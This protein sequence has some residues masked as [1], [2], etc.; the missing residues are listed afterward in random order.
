MTGTCTSIRSL[1]HLPLVAVV[2][3]LACMPAAA[4]QALT[5]YSA[6]Y[7]VKLS[8]LSGSLTTNL[9]RTGD[10]YEAVH[11]IVPT[12]LARIIKN[13]SIRE[14]SRFATIGDGVR[15]SWYQSADSLSKD[16]P[17]AEVEFDWSSNEMSGTVNGE[18]VDVALDGLVHD[19]VAIQYELMLDLLNGGPGDRYLLFDIDEFKTLIVTKVGEKRIKTPA[20][21]Y[22]AI[23]I[24]HQS[25]NSSRVTTLWCAAALGYLPVLI[26][27]HRK[28]KLQMRATLRDYE[29][30]AD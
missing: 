13:G 2:A 18:S 25:E 9:R 10:G 7:K 21:T 19:R 30:A 23:G 8:I 6:E 27:Q 16:S 14:Q 20:G 15:T 26:E 3:V 12:G 29:A 22:E 28:G 4:Q 5:P 24:Q 17:S 1:R 11:E